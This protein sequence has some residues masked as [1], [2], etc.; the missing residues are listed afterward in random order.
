MPARKPAPPSTRAQV[1]P[2]AS[3]IK[4]LA[5]ATRAIQALE[6]AMTELTRRVMKLEG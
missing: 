3:G 6:A 2:Q 5:G 1:V 4:D